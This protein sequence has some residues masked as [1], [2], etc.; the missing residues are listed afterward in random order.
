MEISSCLFVFNISY[1]FVQSDLHLGQC[2]CN[3]FEAAC[4]VYT[5]IPASFSHQC[6]Q[7]SCFCSS[8]A[9]SP[10]RGHGLFRDPSDARLLR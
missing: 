4:C 6:A 7:R 9:Q 3:L 8:L 5:F 10:W 2:N 1:T